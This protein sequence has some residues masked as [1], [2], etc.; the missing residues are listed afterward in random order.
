MSKYVTCPYCNSNLDPGEIC[1]C[2]R[3]RQLETPRNGT[4][5]NV[6]VRTNSKLRILISNANSGNIPDPVE[7]T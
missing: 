2:Q 3:Q 6:F 4:A 5:S 7:S 1:D